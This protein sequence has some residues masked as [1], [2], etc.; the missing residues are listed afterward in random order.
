LQ[1]QKSNHECLLITIK[2]SVNILFMAGKLMNFV[3][4]FGMKIV[5]VI[6]IV[7]TN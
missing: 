7:D 3:T 2:I 5:T 4:L 6:A 1:N